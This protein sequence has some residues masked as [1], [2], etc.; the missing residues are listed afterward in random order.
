ME[1]MV[2]SG[3]RSSE[4]RPLWICPKCGARLISRNLWHSCGRFTLES[5]FRGARPDVL[6]LAREFIRMLQALGDVQVIP[7]K[8]RL[9]CVARVRFGGLYPRKGG[10]RVGFALRRWIDSPRIVKTVDY[11]PRWRGHFV[12]VQSRDDL[13]SELRAWLQEAHDTV[14]MQDD[15]R[16]RAPRLPNG[17][18]P[19]KRSQP[20]RSRQRA[21]K[22]PR[23]AARR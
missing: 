21:E 22:K 14:G 19:G 12:A 9:V 16:P 23:R 5:L 7:Q 18:A 11:G 15:L 6:E 17:A 1:G 20:L 10:F 13:D 8:T 2:R 3:P 4:E